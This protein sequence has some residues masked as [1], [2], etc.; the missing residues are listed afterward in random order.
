ML[1]FLLADCSQEVADVKTGEEQG[2]CRNGRGHVDQIV[3]VTLLMRH[4]SIWHRR[5]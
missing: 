5:S 2:N 3:T 1:E 4:T